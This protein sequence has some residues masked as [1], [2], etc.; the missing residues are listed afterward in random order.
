MRVTERLTN[1]RGPFSIMKNK[2]HIASISWPD[3]ET[4]E[5]AQ[6]RAKE[7]GLTLSAYIN[8][9]VHSDIKGGG[10]LVITS[11]KSEQD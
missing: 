1:K 7:L 10:D 5:R 3:K 2:Y 6:K 9:L 4:K 8:L 11:K